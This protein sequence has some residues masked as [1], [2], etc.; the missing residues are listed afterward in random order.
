MT[1][2]ISS[3]STCDLLP[4]EHIEKNQINILPL[5][6]S[7]GDKMYKDNVDITINEVLDYV[8]KGGNLPKTS[9]I[10]VEEYVDFFTKLTADGSELI[11]FNI[12]SKSSACYE[13]AVLAA[14]KVKGVY[15]VN[16]LQ[17]SSGQGLLIM[18]ACDLR[19]AG[20]SA[21]EVFEKIEQIKLKAKTSFVVDRLDYLHKGGR[22]SLL[23]LLG[24]KMLKIHPHISMRDGELYVKKKYMG[25]LERSVMLYVQDLASEYGSYD[26]T[27]CFIT[28]CNAS[29]EIVNI[30]KT[31]VKELFNFD[32]IEETHAGTTVGSHCGRNTIGV[33]FIE[34]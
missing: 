16:T 30:V 5:T 11:H 12:S 13:H 8:D 20:F 17:L 26:K 18:K 33:L 14:E 4:I 9:A 3:D 29:P 2:K 1:F 19:N 28:H 6:I 23:A 27:R 31:K 21:K 32:L 7:L 22:C 10:S 15:V 24:A 34:E 25:S